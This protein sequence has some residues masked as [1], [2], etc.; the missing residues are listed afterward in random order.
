MSPP[1]PPRPSP[2]TTA[3][4][5][6]GQGRAGCR[7]YQPLH[8]PVTPPEQPSPPR[9]FPLPPHPDLGAPTFLWAF[10]GAGIFPSPPSR[11]PRPQIP[12]QDCPV[13]SSKICPHPPFQ[14][15]ALGRRPHFQNSLRSPLP[16]APPGPRPGHRQHTL[17]TACLT[18]LLNTFSKLKICRLIVG[19]V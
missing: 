18:L 12:E 4:E 13:K 16:G 19:D 1:L 10:S 3:P 15:C 2:E 14:S 7:G 6:T 9:T 17:S 11:L 8:S 5:A